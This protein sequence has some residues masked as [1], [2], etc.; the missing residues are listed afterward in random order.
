RR[1][2]LIWLGSVCGRWGHLSLLLLMDPMP[3][4]STTLRAGA[5]CGVVCIQTTSTTSSTTRN[6][7]TR[8]ALSVLRAG[9]I[10]GGITNWDSL[11]SKTQKTKDFSVQIR[12]LAPGNRGVLSVCYN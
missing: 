10:P 2:S 1:K 7:R 12:Q 5:I 9:A 8:V 4:E 6:S 11:H 3:I